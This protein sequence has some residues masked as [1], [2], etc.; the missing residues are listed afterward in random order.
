M[1]HYFKILEIVNDVTALNYEIFPKGLTNN[2]TLRLIKEIITTEISRPDTKE[3]DCVTSKESYELN[4][5]I[6]S[7]MKFEKGIW[8]CKVCKKKIQNKM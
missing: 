6:S 2:E 4:A 5:T 1:R 7:M 8:T 3:Q